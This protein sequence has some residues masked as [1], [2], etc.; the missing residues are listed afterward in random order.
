MSEKISVDIYLQPLR[1]LS[2]TCGGI[3]IT[4]SKRLNLENRK[5]LTN[6]VFP[7]DTRIR[8]PPLH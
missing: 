1:R 5:R 8:D 2:I 7:R 6:I 3:I 4:L